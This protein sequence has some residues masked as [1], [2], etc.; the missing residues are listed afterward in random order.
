MHAKVAAAKLNAS[1]LMAPI[2]NPSS[3]YTEYESSL[4]LSVADERLPMDGQHFMAQ[5]VM[6]IAMKAGMFHCSLLQCNLL[7]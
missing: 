7:R 2:L 1:S 5:L 3:V 4:R 6:I